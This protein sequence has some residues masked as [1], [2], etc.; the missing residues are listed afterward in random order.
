M[1]DGNRAESKS[2]ESPRKLDVPDMRKSSYSR[3]ESV[4]SFV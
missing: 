3:R 2:N 1:K 4:S